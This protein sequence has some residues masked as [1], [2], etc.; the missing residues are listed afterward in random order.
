MNEFF[1]W[2]LFPSHD[3]TKTHNTM[4]ITINSTNIAMWIDGPDGAPPLDILKQMQSKLHQE[5]TTNRKINA[6]IRYINNAKY[7][8]SPQQQLYMTIAGYLIILITYVEANTPWT[9]LKELM[10]PIL[11]VAL[12]KIKT[13]GG[14]KGNPFESFLETAEGH[15]D[16]YSNKERT[17]DIV[18]DPHHLH[19]KI[20]DPQSCTIELLVA[21]FSQA[22][23]LMDEK[24]AGATVTLNEM[25]GT[26]IY[27][28]AHDNRSFGLCVACSYL[29]MM[30]LEDV[31]KE[32]TD[33][34]T[35]RAIEAL[36]LRSP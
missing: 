33:E 7:F 8:D 14:L 11:S 13:S 29:A 25:I 9:G 4:N 35:Q 30:M 17:I 22:F 16:D 18:F 1:D 15:L 12:L 26:M 5:R 31:R 27:R 23:A 6:L 34:L 32:G 36:D 21:A 28:Y 10:E 19:D 2:L 3:P 24:P 20:Q